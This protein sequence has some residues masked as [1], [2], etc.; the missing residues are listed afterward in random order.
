MAFGDKVTWPFEQTTTAPM[1]I[2]DDGLLTFD[3]VQRLCQ[4]SKAA[5]Y[6]NMSKGKFPLPIK[7]A[8]DSARWL[9][10]ELSDYLLSR[11]LERNQRLATQK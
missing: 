6:D 11:V 5:I 2:H 10:Q 9:R 7:I 4:L 1:V 3:Q 8:G